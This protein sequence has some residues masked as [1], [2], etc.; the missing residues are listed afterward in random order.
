MLKFCKHAHNDTFTEVKTCNIFYTNMTS[1]PK[2]RKI[3]YINIPP[4]MFS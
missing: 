3:P 1:G 2:F 4:F